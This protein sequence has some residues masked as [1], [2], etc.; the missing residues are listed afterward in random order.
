MTAIN[1]VFDNHQVKL[2]LFNWQ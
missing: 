2:Q 1:G